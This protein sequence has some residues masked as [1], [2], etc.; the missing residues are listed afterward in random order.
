LHFAVTAPAGAVAPAFFPVVELGAIA[1]ASFAVVGLGVAAAVAFFDVVLA[2]LVVV[3]AVA[4]LSVLVVVV[5]DLSVLVVEVDVVDLSD[6]V[7]VDVVDF[8]DGQVTKWPEASRHCF[9]LASPAPIRATAA[10]AASRLDGWRMR[11]LLW[12][13]PNPPQQRF[14]TAPVPPCAR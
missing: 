12:E 6:G 14:A 3:L 11:S 8:S 5:A 9:A 4:A 10:T 1:E 2:P 7:E 13:P